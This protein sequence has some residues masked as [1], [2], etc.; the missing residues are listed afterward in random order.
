MNSDPHGPIFD[1]PKGPSGTNGIS[2]IIVTLSN[3]HTQID[4]YLQKEQYWGVQI[5][6]IYKYP[7]TKLRFYLTLL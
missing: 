2:I 3:L 1:N 4:G 5:Y 7:D 6:H